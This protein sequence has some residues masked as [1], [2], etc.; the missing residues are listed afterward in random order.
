M[1]ENMMNDDM[2]FDD[3]EAM[4]G[5]D[6]SDI[7]RMEKVVLSQNLEGFANCFPDWDLHPPVNAKS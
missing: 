4:F 1:A 6:S 3:L 5:Q 7:A 2:N